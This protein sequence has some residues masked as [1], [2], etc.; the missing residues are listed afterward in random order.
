MIRRIVIGVIALYG[1][2]IAYLY[3]TQDRQ[4]FP[5]HL[6]PKEAPVSGDNI[7]PLRLNIEDNAAVLDGVLRKDEEPN[8]DLILYFGGNADDATRF[9]LEAKA[10]QGYDI[11]AFNYRGY[12]QST[13]KPSEEAF[14]SDA[15]KI[16][17][18]YA[19]GRKV[20]VIGRSLGTGVATHL[21]TKRVVDGLVL[22]TPYDSIVSIG[23]R[24]Y[25]FF[26]I[27]LLINNPFE[28]INEI[29][30]VK[31]PIAVMEVENDQTIPRY[32]LEK[33]IEKIPGDFLHVTLRGTT[34]G[35]VLEHPEF[36]GELQTIL[37]KMNEQMLR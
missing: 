16:Y 36:T 35:A 10:L 8:A 1:V 28:T 25:P 24:K 23:Q 32:H 34:H 22:I 19:R 13:G 9:V 2:A 11:I 17:D 5:A 27:A 6:I 33:L 29:P 15:L 30:L 14:F 7:T 18:A 31:A 26:P 21:A 20:F 37:G 4:I 3:W 12:V